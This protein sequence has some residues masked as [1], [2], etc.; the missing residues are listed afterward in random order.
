MSAVTPAEPRPRPVL[1]PPDWDVLTRDERRTLVLGALESRSVETLWD[2]TQHNLMIYGRGGSNTSAHTLRG[3]R[4]GVMQFL[5]YA[6]RLGWER[7]TIHDTDL[8]VGYIR[9]LER[10]NLQPGT[11]N[12]R[13]SAARAFYRALRWAGVLSADPFAD[14]PR[15][16]DPVAR[17][18]RRDAYS[19]EDVAK[20]LKK[21]NARDRLMILLGAHGALRISEVLALTWDRVNLDERTIRVTGKGNKTAT[22]HMSAQLYEALSAVQDRTGHVCGYA[23]AKTLRSHLRAL[24][25]AT[26]VRYDRRQFHGLRHA[27]ATM[28][29][30]DTNDLFV[31]MRHLR[32]SSV[33]TTEIYAKFDSKKLQGALTDWGSDPQDASA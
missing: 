16:Q 18:D 6:Y 11:I 22:V 32:H 3:Y 15:A 26:G 29:L 9:H 7:M 8:T 17:W 13:R 2:L 27:S 24:C 10:E 12:S 19:R 25:L 21:A 23:S 14:T 4:T 30:Q 33:G 5:Q 20:L 1:A 28:L 31:V